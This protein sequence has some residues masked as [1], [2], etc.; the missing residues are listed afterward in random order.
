MQKW[1][2]TWNVI[3]KSFKCKLQTNSPSQLKYNNKTYDNNSSIANGFNDYCI[4]LP[5]FLL[6]DITPAPEFSKVA[7]YIKNLPLQNKY[8]SF[9]KI[10]E[11]DVLHVMEKMKN[12]N[13]SGVDTISNEALKII[14]HSCHNY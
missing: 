9:N 4:N 14:K 3:N 1:S 2:K 5:K 7:G 12:T 8:F 6:S 11:I 13:S 10:N